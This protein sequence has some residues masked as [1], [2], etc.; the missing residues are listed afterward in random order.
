MSLKRTKLHCDRQ[1]P[2]EATEGGSFPGPKVHTNIQED[3]VYMAPG[4]EDKKD[5][6]GKTIH[7]LAKTIKVHQR[8][9]AATR[10]PC[11]IWD[12]DDHWDTVYNGSSLKEEIPV[13]PET[14][15][16]ASTHGWEQDENP[17]TEVPCITLR[18]AG[19]WGLT[20][21]LGPYLECCY[22]RRRDLSLTINSL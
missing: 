21:N 17:H 19:S 7:P 9:A 12:A 18:T 15:S 11:S 20:T 22:S 3:G 8:R 13:R 16:I 5:S 10:T 1:Q 6:R 2:A 14:R 4:M